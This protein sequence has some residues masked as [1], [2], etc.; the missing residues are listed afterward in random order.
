MRIIFP[1][2]LALAIRQVKESF[3][4]DGLEE[5]QVEQNKLDALMEIVRYVNKMDYIKSNTVKEKFSFFLRNKYSYK[6][7]ADKFN[8]SHVNN[9]EV[10]ISRVSKD[11]ERMVGKEIIE[12]ILAGKVSEA[13]KVFRAGTMS[14]PS[15]WYFLP[16]VVKYLPEPKFEMFTT[17][18]EWTSVNR[19]DT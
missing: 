15:M 9:I 18:D 11:L 17:V 4:K 16:E 12:L 19:L 14:E 10:M 2:K 8:E 6:L 7:T 13:M 5:I 1:K 3:P